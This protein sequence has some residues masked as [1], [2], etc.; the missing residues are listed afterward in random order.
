MVVMR[1]SDRKRAGLVEGAVSVI[2][3]TVLFTSKWYLGVV[4]YSVAILADAV[5]TLSDSL[6]SIVLILSMVLAGKPPDIEHPFGHG[7]AEQVGQLIIGVLLG[8]VG[9]EFAQR[10]YNK[11]VSRETLI[12]SDILVYSLIVFTNIKLLLGIW[13][14]RLG[15][16]WSSNAIVADAWH[17]LSDALA[18]LLLAVAIYFGRHYWWLDGVLGFVVSGLIMYVGIEISWDATSELL[19]RAPSLTE[20]D[21]LRSLIE[22][23]FPEVKHVHHVHYHKYGDH[24]EITLHVRLPGEMSLKNAHDIASKIEELIRNK[25]GYEA[26]V[27]VEPYT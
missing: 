9:V 26:T 22:S 4:Y 14:Y 13:A 20:I 21:D 17:H 16:K 19:G 10:S 11:L 18:T 8:V 23:I 5:H 7:R 2:V 6:T 24:V 12:Y 1:I 25:Y 3:N 27:H 15:R